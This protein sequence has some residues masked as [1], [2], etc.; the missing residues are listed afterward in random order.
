MLQIKQMQATQSKVIIISI[1]PVS[2]KNQQP[3]QIRISS[4]MP[5]HTNLYSAKIVKTNLRRCT[6]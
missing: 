3:L 6:L 4:V 5:L 2:Q 1:S